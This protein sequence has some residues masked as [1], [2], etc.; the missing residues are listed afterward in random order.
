[1]K[2]VRIGAGSGY[3]GDRIE[4]A[5]E[6]LE[7]GN[8]DYLVFEALAERTIARENLDKLKDSSKGFNPLLEER[9]MRSLPIAK[10]KGIPIIT[11]MGAANPES[12]GE[13][14]CK[15]GEKLGLNNLKIAVI[16]GDDVMETINGYN[17]NLLETDEPLHTIEDKIESANAYL[18]ADIIAKALTLGP[19]VVITG[20][21]GDPSL[22]LA[23]MMHALN[24][25]YDDY[26]KIGQGSVI[27]HLMECAGQITGGYF[28]DPGYKDVPNLERLG[29]PICEVYEDGKAFITKVEAS[30]G[31]VTTATC[32][33]QMLYE[34]HDPSEYITPDCVVD[35]TNVTFK[36]V[37]KDKVEVI[38][39]RAKPRTSTYKVSIGYRNGFI[40]EGQ[41]SYGGPGA[42]SRAKLAGDIVK[43]RLSLRN[44]RTNHL[45]VD[46]I[47]IASL[48]Q[49]ASD[50]LENEPYEVR[51]R[52]AGIT[53]QYDD[54]VKIGQE[55]ET[56]LTN[57]PYGGAGDFKSVREIIAVLSILLPRDM[58]KTDI[59]IKELN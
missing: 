24:W 32:K 42:V 29:F 14:I 54:A 55:V 18:G 1:M 37:A 56:L 28:A 11:N 21:V 59:V 23:P 38:G 19:D 53:P 52:V 16:I 49:E 4:P 5:I 12:A 57:G 46:Y 41:M 43:K 26:D 20:R 40:G 27:G 3:A 50:W 39:G 7:K 45:Q 33:E 6:L 44:V 47:G 22:F 15:I 34:I 30:G 13:L 51:L 36:E 10:K 48:H 58:V 9:M 35:F 17:T 25:S 2:K 8:I 31:T